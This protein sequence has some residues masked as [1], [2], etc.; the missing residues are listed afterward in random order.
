MQ[1]RIPYKLLLIIWFVSWGSE[2]IIAASGDIF[3]VSSVFHNFFQVYEEESVDNMSKWQH[4]WPIAEDFHRHTS[5]AVS[6]TRLVGNK[7]LGIQG[8]LHEHLKALGV[9][10]SS[11]ECYPPFEVGQTC[12]ESSKDILLAEYSLVISL[13]KIIGGVHIN[14]DL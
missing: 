8:A 13:V 1:I 4:C 2:L 3:Q 6:H 7:S 11:L 10:F 12:F 14:D 5:N 9:N